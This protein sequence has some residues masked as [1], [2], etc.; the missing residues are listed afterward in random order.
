[1]SERTGVPEADARALVELV[2][3]DQLPHAG[4][5]PVGA[6]RE[7][8]DE[9]ALL[10]A[11]SRTVVSAAETV[12]SAVVSIAVGGRA[13]RPVRRSYGRGIGGHHRA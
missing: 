13:E 3:D 4:S 9:E 10:D 8:I 11:Y 7:A 12:G 5:A 2:A 6:D 1:M